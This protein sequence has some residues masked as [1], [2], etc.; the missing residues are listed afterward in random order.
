MRLKD[1][2]RYVQ[3]QGGER[4]KDRERMSEKDNHS[5]A[6]HRKEDERQIAIIKKKGKEWLEEEKKVIT[7]SFFFGVEKVRR[8]KPRRVRTEREKKVTFL[9][10]LS[11]SLSLVLFPW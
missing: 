10:H 7:V 9:T 6:N 1:E 11:L 5:H 2:K 4:K 8:L 3:N